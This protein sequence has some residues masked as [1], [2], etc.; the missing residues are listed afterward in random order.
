MEISLA[1]KK[2]L[3]EFREA[4]PDERTCEAYLFRRRWPNG[5]VCRECR[6]VDC[7]SRTGRAFT[8]QCSRCRR[9][10][11]I[12]AGT[13]MQ[14]SKLELTTWFWA[15]GLIATYP[16]RISVPHFQVLFAISAQSARLL[17]KKFGLLVDAFNSTQGQLESLVEVD[18]A[19]FQLRAADGSVDESSSGRIKIV[20]AIEISSGQIR[21]ALLPDN[22]VTS[23]EGFVRSNVKRGATLVTNGHD[24]YR[25]LIEYPTRIGTYL[26]K[27]GRMLALSRNY[28]RRI[29][30]HRREDIGYALDDFVTY[31]NRR[32]RERQTSFETLIELAL[33]EKPM[34]HWDIV[35]RENPRKGTPT[36]R[37]N[38]RHRRTATGMRQDGSGSIRPLRVTVGPPSS[39]SH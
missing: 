35:G 28:L 31:Q 25:G 39:E 13:A 29:N 6:G 9:Q 30:G 26:R 23:I 20:V 34:T 32:A 2:T 38:P 24:A 14:R 15:A 10:I 18:F 36:V 5:F 16:A 8:Y 3:A 12:T 37:R 7:A 11:S 33:D 22:S 19:E 1:V 17:I 27:T 21:A 4:F